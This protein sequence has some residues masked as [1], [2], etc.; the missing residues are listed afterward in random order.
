VLVLLHACSFSRAVLVDMLISM[1]DPSSGA[2]MQVGPEDVMRAFGEV[3]KTLFRAHGA[4]SSREQGQRHES[5]NRNTWAAIVCDVYQF[6]LVFRTNSATSSSQRE[7]LAALDECLEIAE[8][9][10]VSVLG[11]DGYVS[12]L[13][14][15]EI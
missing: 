7:E 13:Y 11:D 6:D 2:E 3:H 15:N 1:S 10:Y 12:V 4:S 9:V 14:V 5:E 8:R